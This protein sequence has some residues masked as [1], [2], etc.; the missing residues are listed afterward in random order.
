MYR[1]A[2]DADVYIAD[3]TAAN[4]NVYL[5]LG[6]R[7]ALKDGVTIPIAQNLDDVRFNVSATRVIPYGPMPS[8]L[9]LATQQITDAAVDGLMHPDRIDSPVRD[10]LLLVAVTRQDWDGLRGEIERLKDQRAED[11]VAGARAAT[12]PSDR[13]AL[14]Q[15]A[16]ARNPA[17]VQ[18]HID[19]G[20]E[21]RK[22]ARYGAAA[23]ELR[24]ATQ[25]DQTNPTAWRELGVALSKDGEHDQAVV[26]LEHAARLD[27]R[28]A[29]TWSNLGGTLRRLARRNGGPGFDPVQLQR[30]Q[31]A[32][33]RAAR[34]SGNDT[35][36]LM[37]AARIGLLLSAAAPESRA[38]ALAVFHDLRLLT[39]FAVRDTRHEDPWK[40]FDFADTLMLT[41]HVEGAVEAVRQGVALIP[42][43]N[44][45]SFLSSAIEPL[46]DL[47]SIPLLD[48]ELGGHVSRLIDEYRS[49]LAAVTG[50]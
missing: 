24:R 41:G 3:L 6:V 42:L 38:A 44:R 8:A 47:R 14:L 35:Y 25:I 17:N 29:E 26:A 27:D 7:W 10:S 37:N 49:A 13:I 16:I 9:E 32:Y 23:D 30:A 28:D 4:P 5:E 39:E 46:E 15:E 40:L 33:N 2:A 12:T 19:L 48:D 11:L 21:L 22:T 1:E 34:L 43:E 45:V 20:V 18:A 50:S 31:D 36:P